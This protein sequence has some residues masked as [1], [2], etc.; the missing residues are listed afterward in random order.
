[1]QARLNGRKSTRLQDGSSQCS[2]RPS[3]SALSLIAKS[4]SLLF[5]L[6]ENWSELLELVWPSEVMNRSEHHDDDLQYV[7]ELKNTC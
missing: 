1:M 7:T 4:A 6:L 2:P 3:K 5:L